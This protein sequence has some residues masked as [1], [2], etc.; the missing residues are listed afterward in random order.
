MSFP[1]Q[2]PY[3]RWFPWLS[4]FQA[5]EISLSMRHLLVATGVIAV[6]SLSHWLIDRVAPDSRPSFQLKIQIGG[7]A[8][9]QAASILP[10]ESMVGIALPWQEVLHSVERVVGPFSSSASGVQLE[11]S[12]KR[13]ILIE[14]GALIWKVAV[15]TLFGLILCRLSARRFAKRENGSF[16]KCVQFG[17][18]RWSRGL[19]APLIPTAAATLILGGMVTM[20]GLA[21][22]VPVFNSFVMTV[23]SPL[24]LVAGIVAGFLIVATLLGW[25]LMVAA[26]AYDDCD[27]F[28]GLSRSYSQWTGR[29]WYFAWCW[30]I[31]AVAGVVALTLSRWLAVWAFYLCSETIKSGMG[32]TAAATIGLQNIQFLIQL[33]LQAYAISFFWTGATIV[34]AL[35]RQSVDW[36]PCDTIAPDDDER[37]VRDPLPVVGIPAMEPP[38]STT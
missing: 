26:I 13:S 22:A 4:L 32:N 36:M 30:A 3:R 35:L 21:W 2:I 33:L 29:P 28:G 31:V 34:Y 7:Q 17:V 1:D 23:F 25:P 24:L 16:R 5:I 37:P 10:L 38:A 19:I 27:G 12:Q 8:L 18:T 6:F 15:W 20:T 9:P 11:I 14:I